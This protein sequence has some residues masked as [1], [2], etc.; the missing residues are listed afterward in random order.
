MKDLVF[1]AFEPKV[2][3][4]RTHRFPLAYAGFGCGCKWRRHAQP[5]EPA[6]ARNGECDIPA[7]PAG[8][9]RCARHADVPTL[10]QEEIDG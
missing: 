7:L 6:S 3:V 2:R 1:A 5:F 4:P 10:T 9:T 8:W